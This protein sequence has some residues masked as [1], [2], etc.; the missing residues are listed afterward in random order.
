LLKKDTCPEN[1]PPV[2]GE[3]VMATV[4]VAAGASVSGVVNPVT[5]KT[6]LVELDE[7]TVTLAL[8]V[9]VSVTDWLAVLPT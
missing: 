6:L 2:V 5:V 1:E 3:K 4:A 7:L 8:P 9:L